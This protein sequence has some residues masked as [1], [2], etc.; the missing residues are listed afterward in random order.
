M[1][2]TSETSRTGADA[3][4][5]APVVARCFIGGRWRD[6]HGAAAER[7][8]P[9]TDEVVTQVT[10]AD[11][12]DVDDAVAAAVAARR[13]WAETA[14]LSRG[15]L[16]HRAADL[17][18]ERAEE[19]ARLISR[20]MGKTLAESREDVEYAADDLRFAAEDALRH[21]G[22]VAPHTTDP[23]HKRKKV[24]MVHAPVGVA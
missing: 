15:K 7:R 9:T 3:D 14:V 18:L 6:G 2:A 12:N 17:L 4:G 22:Q 5:G 24:L 10:Y 11:G 20:E 1:S 23:D 13:E 16:L 21:F 8:S 19:A